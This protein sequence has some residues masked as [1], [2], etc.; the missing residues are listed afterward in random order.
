MPQLENVL[1]D[2]AKYVA[3]FP[4]SPEMG[5]RSTRHIAVLTCMDCRLE[6]GPSMGIQIP[7]GNV[8]RNAGGRASDDALRSLVIS[9]RL[10]GVREIFV[11]HHSD[12]GMF[13]Y[14]D[15]GIVDLLTSADPS[16]AEEAAAISWQTIDDE[17]E[18]VRED[19]RTIRDYALIPNSIPVHGLILDPKSGKLTVIEDGYSKT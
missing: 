13:K 12:C 8:L 16:F 18:S 6:P 1:K 15:Q 19:V 7:E 10:L 14:S 5:P 3:T 4:Y 9:V 11:V 2:N 17:V